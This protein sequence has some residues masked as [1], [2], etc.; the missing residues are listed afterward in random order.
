MMIART[1]T[2]Q[3][4]GTAAVVYTFVLVAQTRMRRCT[5]TVVQRRTHIKWFS[6][7][8]LPGTDEVGEPRG[9]EIRV[10]V[11]LQYKVVLV[12][13]LLLRYSLVHRHLLVHR[14]KLI[15]GDVELQIAEILRKSDKEALGIAAYDEEQFSVCSYVGLPTLREDREI[16]INL[17][18]PNE[19]KDEHTPSLVWSGMV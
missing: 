5:L 14:R 7:T 18:C 16:I 9:F 15:I 17:G 13:D 8:Q 3:S 19:A 12:H 11:Q 4:Y 10:R 2:Q 6:R 1:L